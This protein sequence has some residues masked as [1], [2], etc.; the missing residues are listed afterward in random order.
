[1]IEVCSSL[2]KKKKM[3]LKQ[4][5]KK[6]SGESTAE[7]RKKRLKLVDGFGKK[8][9]DRNGANMKEKSEVGDLLDDDIEEFVRSFDRKEEVLN[10]IRIR[11]ESYLPFTEQWN[12]CTIVIEDLRKG[13]AED[14]CGSDLPW[15][16]DVVLS[17]Y[18]ERDDVCKPFS[19]QWRLYDRCLWH[20]HD[21]FPESDVVSSPVKKVKSYGKAHEKWLTK[22]KNDYNDYAK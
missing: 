4:K 17:W 11:D 14:V 6:R 9:E 13:L 7:V 15:R 10:L 19:T 8:G 12:R 1:V 18:H 21:I 5:A 16:K 20:Q 3:G 22:K 2:H